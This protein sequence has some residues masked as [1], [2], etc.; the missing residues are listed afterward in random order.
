M[1]RPTEPAKLVGVVHAKELHEY[2]AIVAIDFG[3]DGSGLAYCKVNTTKND[4]NETILDLK[5]KNKINI[6]DWGNSTDKINAKTK[7]CIL[8]PANIIDQQ[9]IS[10][11]KNIE[12]EIIFGNAAMES[13]INLNDAKT[14]GYNSDDSSGSNSSSESADDP[15]KPALFQ[16]FKMKLWEQ[17][18]NRDEKINI[19]DT[20]NSQDNRPSPADLVF[21]SALKFMQSKVK[22]SLIKDDLISSNDDAWTDKVKWILTVPAIWSGI[23]ILY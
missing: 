2:N 1:S 19:N 8:I 23:V 9:N 22:K 21:I 18:G 6:V 11:I 5:Q 16:K 15:N 13:Y 10:N 4:N 3:T 17:D 7:T 12:N 14:D 20:I